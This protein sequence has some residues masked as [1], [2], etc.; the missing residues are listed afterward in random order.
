MHFLIYNLNKINNFGNSQNIQ[1]PK[2]KNLIYL[3]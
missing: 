3:T 2:N 1:A